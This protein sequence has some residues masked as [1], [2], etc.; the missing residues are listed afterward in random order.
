MT[1]EDRRVSAAECV[2]ELPRKDEWFEGDA[3]FSDQLHRF[4]Q[5]QVTELLVG[6]DPFPFA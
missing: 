5:E 3:A 4:V 6:S 2:S 1:N